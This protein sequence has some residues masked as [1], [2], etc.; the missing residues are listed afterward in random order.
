[1]PATLYRPSTTVLVHAMEPLDS[2][3]LSTLKA[4]AFL[5][6]H[7]CASK[8]ENDYIEK[9]DINGDLCYACWYNFKIRW[10]VRA[11]ALALA[12]LADYHPGA[13]LSTRSLTFANA[14][15]LPYQFPVSAARKLILENPTQ[16]PVAGGLVEVTFDILSL[17]GP[18]T[19]PIIPL[20]LPALESG[21]TP[22]LGTGADWAGLYGFSTISLRTLDV[23]GPIS[24]YSHLTDFEY[25]QTWPR[26][27]L[28]PADYAEYTATLDTLPNTTGQEIREIFATD[29]PG[30]RFITVPITGTGTTILTKLRSGVPDPFPAPGFTHIMEAIQ[31]GGGGS[32]AGGYFFPVNAP[33]ITTAAEFVAAGY[34]PPGSELQSLWSLATLSWLTV[35]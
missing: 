29:V 34:L 7:E 30:G 21:L 4:E 15:R 28:P 26:T 35:P 20:P 10:S 14:A 19:G 5:L 31:P 16:N 27:T 8:A 33:G 18:S 23:T 32:G 3:T 6:I 9:T 12:G 25:W 11:D 13:Q 2:A 22:S 1:M 24:G 17:F